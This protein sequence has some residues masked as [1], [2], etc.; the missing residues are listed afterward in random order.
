M[1]KIILTDACINGIKNVKLE[2][3]VY[4]E[5]YMKLVKE[6]NEKIEESLRERAKTYQKAKTFICR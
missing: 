6:A 1:A 4:S 2:K 3:P 5:E